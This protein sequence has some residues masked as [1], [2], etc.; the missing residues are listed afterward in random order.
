MF[1]YPN[2]DPVA[3]SLGPLNIHWY[4]IS[5]LLGFLLCWRILL[6]M[7]PMQRQPWT[8]EALWDL[9]SYGVFGVIL[10]GRMG[11]VLFYGFEQFLNDPLSLLRIW[12]GGMSFHGGLL[13]VI[14]ALALYARRTGRRFLDVT[15]FVAPG[16]P[17]ALG[18]GRVGNFINGELPGRITDVPWALIYPGDVVGRHPS[19]LYQMSLEGPVL[20][21]LVYLIARR[22]R[23]LGFNSGAFLVLYALFR[24]TTEFFRA[25]DPHM[26]FVALGWMTQGQALCVPMVILG[27]FLMVRSQSHEGAANHT[28]TTVKNKARTRKTK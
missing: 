25:P 10:G 15:D 16:A 20:F 27:L 28:I 11:Y 7:S 18:L 24:F 19:S 8:R 14:A 3:V 17:L 9:I 21:A 2:I 1:N 13:G 5:Y 12:Q 6:S 26:G 4:A 23:G 22:R